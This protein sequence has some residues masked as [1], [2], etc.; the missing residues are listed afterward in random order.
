MSAPPREQLRPTAR[1]RTCRTE[2][3]NASV[4]WPDSVRPEASVIVPE[5][6]IGKRRP[7]RSKYDS[8]ANK[9]ALPFSVSKIVST[10][11]RSAP[12]SARLSIASEYEATSSSKRTLRAPGSLTSGEIDAVRLVGPSAPATKRGLAGVRALQESAHSRASAVNAAFNSN[13]GLV[14][15]LRRPQRVAR[16]AIIAAARARDLTRRAHT[17]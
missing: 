7:L 13:I 4:V 17:C 8:S 5:T 3:Q 14:P 9:A 2:F 12:P 11:K 10:R 1:G 16:I 15:R 6:M